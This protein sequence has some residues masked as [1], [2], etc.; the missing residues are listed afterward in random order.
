MK[1]AVKNAVESALVAVVAAA[2]FLWFL[3]GA[4][5]AEG[6]ETPKVILL[7]LG[8][9][10]SIITHLVFMVQAAHLD[11]RSRVLWAVLLC[12]TF[13]IASIVLLAQLYTGASAQEQQAAG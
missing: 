8:M 7:A 11:G 12:V 1:P 5:N 13:P 10:A 6:E 9:A 4:A 2:T 3:V